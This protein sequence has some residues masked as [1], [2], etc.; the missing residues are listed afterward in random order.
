[1]SES[2]ILTPYLRN[3]LKSKF[4]HMKQ[5]AHRGEAVL[6]LSVIHV[7]HHITDKH[8]VCVSENKLDS[9]SY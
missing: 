8:W 6:V 2:P 9:G 5:R 1:M 3:P 7:K 4:Q